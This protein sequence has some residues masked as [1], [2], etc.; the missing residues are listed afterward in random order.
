MAVRVCW[1]EHCNT[2]T[3]T[4]DSK[5]IWPFQLS[6]NCKEDCMAVNNTDT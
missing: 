6:G 2:V 4:F 5:C 3:V 1:G